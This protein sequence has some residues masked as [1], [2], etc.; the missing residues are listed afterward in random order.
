MRNVKESIYNFGMRKPKEDNKGKFY[1]REN[2]VLCSLMRTLLD[3][4]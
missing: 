2:A 3:Q 1:G 4:N